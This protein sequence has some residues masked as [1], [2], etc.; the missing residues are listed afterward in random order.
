MLFCHPTTVIL[1]CSQFYSGHPL[2]LHSWQ[3]WEWRPLGRR[4]PGLPA[5]SCT[6]PT[7][8][9]I[10]TRLT[11]FTISLGVGKSFAASAVTILQEILEGTSIEQRVKE[12]SSMYIEY[13]KEF[14]QQWFLDNAVV[15]LFPS[16]FVSF[17]VSFYIP[18]HVF[19]DVA[20]TASQGKPKNTLHPED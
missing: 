18:M 15:P 1:L 11:C 9:K 13:C 20:L 16:K 5:C 2:F 17:Q 7:R 12:I 8:R 10:S 3:P 19:G 4:S 14:W 6:T